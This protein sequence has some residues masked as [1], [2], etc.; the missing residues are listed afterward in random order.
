MPEPIITPVLH[1]SS[2]RGRLPAGIVERL[3]GRAHREDDEVV[4]L[5]LLLRLHPLVGIEG[6]VGAV[7]ARDLAGDLGRQIG[8]VEGVDPPRAALA[9]DQPRARSARRRRRAASPCPGL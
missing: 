2:W 9:L 8:D 6:A 7:A 1:C 4:D 5:A 3:R